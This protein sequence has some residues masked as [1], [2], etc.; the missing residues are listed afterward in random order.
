MNF[1]KNEDKG[2][3]FVEAAIAIA[4]LS[5]LSAI[6]IPAFNC[7]RR[8]AISTA[9]Q[10]T[11]RQIKEECET[12][13]IYGIDKFTSTNPDKY[14][15]SASES[16]SCS[17]GTVTLTP[18]NTNLYPTYLYNFADSELSY[19]FKGKT[20][21]S[22][23]ACNKLI[24]GDNF[25]DSRDVNLDYPFVVKDAFLKNECS[26]YVILNAENWEEA[27][28][29]AIKLGGNLVT[30]NS[31]KEYVWLQK[32][33]WYGNKLL[34]ES[35]INSDESTYY[36]VGLNDVNEEGKYVWTS[37]QESEWN[38]NEDLIHRQNW[39]AQQHMANDHDYFVIGGTN[40]KG[41]SDYVQKDYRPD[42]YNG[43]N[44]GTLTWVDNNS[45]W[46]KQG[47][48]PAPHYGLAEIP[49]CNL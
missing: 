7:V 28:K 23:V 9:A 32:N 27:E 22:F 19:N 37:G 2:F 35:G 36:Y 40:D 34:K 16:N 46:N 4:V 29:N 6:A 1:S 17:G 13:Y 11:I 8:R 20:G 41:F 33:L 42:L 5:I 15:I 3:G 47:S 48:N 18:E 30:I 31:A 43:I 38:N 21:T 12:N 26:L 24:C 14:Q 45:S 49:I 25:N 39:L 10:E 44:V